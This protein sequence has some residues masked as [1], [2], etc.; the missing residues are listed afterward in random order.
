MSGALPVLERRSIRTRRERVA[1]ERI[2]NLM[3]LD[4]E[5][6]AGAFSLWLSRRDT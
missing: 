5:K 1:A 3:E 4:T 2:M 6:P